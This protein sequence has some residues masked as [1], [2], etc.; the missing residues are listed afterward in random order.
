[1]EKDQKIAAAAEKQNL[2]IHLSKWF[3]FIAFAL[4][5]LFRVIHAYLGSC[6]TAYG[7][8]YPL[9]SLPLV[10]NPLADAALVAFSHAGLNLLLFDQS[11]VTFELVFC[12]LLTGLFFA[13]ERSAKDKDNV[14]VKL[15]ISTALFTA[16]V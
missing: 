10:R 7:L 3:G 1:M 2:Y 8:I 6:I 13:L 14:L 4:M 5:M 9:M 11:S 16:L 15:A 12:L